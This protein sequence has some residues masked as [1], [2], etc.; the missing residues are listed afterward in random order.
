MEGLAFAIGAPGTPSPIRGQTFCGK[1]IKENI[2]LTSSLVCQNLFF[3]RIHSAFWYRLMLN[4]PENRALKAFRRQLNFLEKHQ[5]E[6]GV[7]LFIFLFG[8]NY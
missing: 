4:G 5:S 2:F 7:L 1:L 3:N 6:V 8:S